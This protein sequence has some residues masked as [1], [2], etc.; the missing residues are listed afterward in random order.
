LQLFTLQWPV[1]ASLVFAELLRWG[2]LLIVVVGGFWL[3]YELFRR[4]N[5]VRSFAELRGGARPAQ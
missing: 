4:F 3:T 1:F 2:R 5:L